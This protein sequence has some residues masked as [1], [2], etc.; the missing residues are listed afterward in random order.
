MVAATHRKKLIPLFALLLA[1]AGM[2]SQTV[3]FITTRAITATNPR[4]A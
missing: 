3:T 1:L 4:I 2:K